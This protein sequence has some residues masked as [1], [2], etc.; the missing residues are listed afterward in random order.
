MYTHI[1]LVIIHIRRSDSEWGNNNKKNRNRFALALSFCPFCFVLFCYFIYRSY[2]CLICYSTDRGGSQVR[3]IEYFDS[4]IG[5]TNKLYC[6]LIKS[7]RMASSVGNR[8]HGE[9]AHFVAGMLRQ[10]RIEFNTEK[11]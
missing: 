9:R 2:I 4:R 11:L 8:S 1:S 7:E 10:T 6:N 3:A 5:N